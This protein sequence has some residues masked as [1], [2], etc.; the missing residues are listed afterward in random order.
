LSDQYSFP[1]AFSAVGVPLHRFSENTLQRCDMS[2][3]RTGV[4]I[5]VPNSRVEATKCRRRHHP[6]DTF[7]R[8]VFCITD[9]TTL[10]SFE[11]E[12]NA[13]FGDLHATTQVSPRLRDWKA[14]R[15]ERDGI[16]N[17]ESKDEEVR[18][19]TMPL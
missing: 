15:A 17:G 18:A 19:H 13:R 12:G 16:A 3:V 4:Q 9:H 10:Q 11:T 14:A 7:R 8:S 5:S 1:N 2:D 6:C